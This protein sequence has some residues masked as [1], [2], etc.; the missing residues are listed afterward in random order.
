M[1]KCATLHE[2]KT[3]PITLLL[4]RMKT[5]KD[6]KR[7]KNDSGEHGNFLDS[8]IKNGLVLSFKPME[9]A[10]MVS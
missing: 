1:D 9:T 2:N 7:L 8:E 4:F 3:A 10:N 6:L 5:F